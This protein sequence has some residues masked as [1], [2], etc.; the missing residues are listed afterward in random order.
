VRDQFFAAVRSLRHRR[1]VSATVVLTL[2]LGVGAN[3]AIFSAVDAV[4]LEP[5]PYPAADRLVAVYELNLGQKGATQL[6]APV[7]IEE[8]NRANR[9]LDGLAGSYFENMT[10]TSAALP[11]RVEA[12]RTSPRFF[13]VLGV[14]A[15][16]GRTPATGEETLGGPPVVVLSDGFWRSRFNGDPSVVGRAITLSGASRTIVGVMPASF[17]YPTATTDVWVPAQMPAVLLRA[18]QAR[19]FTAIGRLKPGVTV[20]QAQSDLDLI[21]SRLGEQFPETDKGWATSLSPLKEEQIGGVRRSLWLLAG[22]VALVLLAACGN[23]AC[24]LLAEAARREHEVA[25]RFALGASRLTVV[26]QL[27]MEGLVLALIGSALGL[28]AA[29]WGTALLRQAAATLPRIQDVRVD[30]RLVAFTVTLGLLTTAL[31]AIAPAL[32]ATRADPGTVLGRRGRGQAGGRHLA[33]RILVAA[34]VALA[35][36]LLVGA[37]LLMRSFAQLQAVSPGFDPVDV[38]VFRMSASWS[39]RTD[40][41]VARQRRTIARLEEIPGVEA[42]AISQALPGGVDYPPAEFGVVGGRTDEHTFAQGRSVSAGYFKT[43]HIPILEGNTCNG[44]QAD[45]LPSEVLVTRAF[46]DRFFS[47]SVPI[48][49]ALTSTGMPAGTGARIVG[50]TSDV[51]ES[52]SL[53][54]ADPLIY[55]CGYNGFWPDPRFLVR[56]RHGRPASLGEIRAALLEIEPQRAVYSVRSLTD[57]LAQTTSQQ[58]INTLLLA[59]FAATAL[60]LAAMGLYGVLS[61]LVAARRREIGVRMALGARAGQILRSVVAQ[62]ATVTGAGIVAGL[63]GAL[64]LTRFMTTLIFGIPAVDPLTFAVVP[65]LL[66]AVALAAALIPARRAA[67]IDPMRALRED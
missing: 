51:H 6:V 11:E 1:G 28:M 32:H 7:R 59:L 38:Q 45:A 3:S 15:A 67:S 22:A 58:W 56:L 26:R 20:E 61:Q 30:M 41:V 2:M 19:F 54:P 12:M 35:I 29:Q 13:S 53:R 33:Q 40:A 46:A 5:L 8:W 49:H 55:W 62:A 43:L 47:G 50:V 31:F 36:V 65:A 21:Q 24:L 16:L 37:G 64:V 63:A 34:Q 17:R 25:V 18:R 14:P 57:A 60:A 23:V 52:G 44:P 27:L 4:L 66:A 48:G 10:D 39:E 9:S 42:A